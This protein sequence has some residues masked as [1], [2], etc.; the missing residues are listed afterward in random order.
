MQVVETIIMSCH[1][2]YFY[3][4]CIA[5]YTR[6]IDVMHVIVM[7]AMNCHDLGISDTFVTL[8][9]RFSYTLCMLLRL[10]Y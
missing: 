5:S 10:L 1:Y 7:I 3:G 4:F 9:A 8:D 2:L 6:L